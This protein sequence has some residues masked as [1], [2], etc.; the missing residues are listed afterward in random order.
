MA[1]AMYD[2]QARPS[3]W[4][5]VGSLADRGHVLTGEP[6]AQHIDGLDGLPVD[7]GD[8][9]QVQGV[10]PVVGEDASDRFVDFGEP[11]CLG[12]EGVFDGEVEPAVPGE[13]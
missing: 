1:A 10:G 8:V 5:E 11:D 12:T 9:A 2:P 7:G 13:E 6:A 3:A 4:S